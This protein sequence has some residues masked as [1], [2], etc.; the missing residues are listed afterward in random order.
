MELLRPCRFIRATDSHRNYSF[1]TLARWHVLIL[2]AP[3]RGSFSGGV[4]VFGNDTVAGNFITP[5][6]AVV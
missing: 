6:Y 3:R 4:G 2:V 5:V 1:P